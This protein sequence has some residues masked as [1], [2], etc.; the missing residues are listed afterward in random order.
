MN[1]YV[2]DPNTLLNES[3]VEQKVIMPLLTN[4]AP[5][6]LG[7]SNINI[8]TKFNLKQL[9]VDKRANSKLYYPDYVIIIEGLPLMA[10]EVKRPGEDLTEAFREARMY[11][12]EMNSFY[13]DINPCTVVIASD[14][15]NLI[16]GSWDN[17]TPLLQIEVGEWS[18]SYYGFNWMI[19]N[20]SLGGLKKQIPILKSKLRSNVFYKKPL[21]L[22]GGKHIQ[23]QAVN[24]TFGES[25]S[26][27]YRHLFNPSHEAERIDVVTNAYIKVE[28]HLSHVDPIDKLIRKKIR[29]STIDS[30]EIDDNKTPREIIDKLKYAHNFNNQVLLLIGSVGSGKSTFT[31]YLKEIALDV[32]LS[33]QLVW[34]R[35]DLNEAPVNSVD[36]YSW[37]KTAIVQDLADQNSD[38]DV[39]EYE[40]VKKI[41]APQID[42][43]DKLATVL[44]EP[45]VYRQSLFELIQNLKGDKDVTLKAFIDF[46]VHSKNKDLIIV[47]D[48]CDKRNLNEQLLM[49][50]VAN[51]LKE[52]T[53]SIVFLPI[54]DTTFDLYRHEKPLDTVI[55]DLIFRINPPSLER[56]LYE[57]IKY[58]SRLSEKSDAKFY[59]LANG[60]TVSYP[61]GEELYY[62][63]SILKSLF[64]N[65]FF[66]SMI[67]GLAGRDI[68][69]GIEIFLDFCKSGHIHEEEIVRMKH[70]KGDYAIPNHIISKVFMRG[71]R[72]YY[73]D[74]GT[75]VKN[76]FYSNVDDHLPN[77][78]S[79]I[80]ILNW[81]KNNSQVKGPSNIAGFHK[82]STIL[83]NLGILGYETERIKEE[84]RSL[85]RSELIISETQ[86]S[87]FIDE[88]ELISINTPGV[89]HLKLLSDIDY[90]GSCA[91]DVWYNEGSVASKISSRMAGKGTYSHLSR[92]SILENSDALIRYLETYYNKYYHAPENFIADDKFFLPLNFESI[93]AAINGKMSSAK[94]YEEKRYGIGEFTKGKIV[95]IYPYA[96]IC[97]LPE[98]QKPGYLHKDQIGIENFY[99]ESSFMLGQY[100]DVEVINYSKKHKKYGLRYLM[101][102]KD[103]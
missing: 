57:R 75:M 45:S 39:H 21:H 71:N 37:L 90:L 29:P 79:R 64:Q 93:L 15:L 38:I 9:K 81:L 52:N 63:R 10:I 78:F 72:V 27:H 48:N 97:E 60:F 98:S 55:K 103:Q 65:S 19:E 26:I 69:K 1:D 53:K 67:S 74:T 62:L 11:A 85:M 40:T 6:G 86:N 42:E 77:P 49:F 31:T 70:N 87:D 41:Y 30:K 73:S 5:I 83:S 35:L 12:T 23:N 17:N 102:D 61:A 43:F 59:Q 18:N 54:R 76:L 20:W 92:H 96:V 99:I 84:L 34:V 24:N 8:Q 95:N 22:L 94:I 51:W 56:V 36:I 89:I 58:A 2:V 3:D 13:P 88:E 33:K 16:G 82:V 32:S 47:L 7:F 25:I 100:I 44:L 46:F 4:L 91:E 68:R 14:G 50:E 101:T 80:S 66:R 28:K